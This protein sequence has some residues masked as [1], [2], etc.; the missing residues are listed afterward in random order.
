MEVHAEVTSVK[1][2]TEACVEVSSVEASTNNFRGSYFHESFHGMGSV[3]ASMEA[4]EA[5][6][7]ASMNFRLK[8]R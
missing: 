5:S 7:E 1:T 4:M 6:I 2:V 3:E 8:R